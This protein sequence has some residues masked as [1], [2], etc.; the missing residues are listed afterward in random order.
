[1]F[2]TNP[3]SLKKLLDQVDEH[4]IMLPD[5][6]R[7]WVWDD[8][9][10]RGL[11]ASVSLGFP[12]GAIMTL[13]AGGDIR[14]KSRPVE[15]VNDAGAK[16][17]PDSFLL[18]GQQRVTSLYQALRREGPVDTHKH[19]H[20]DARIKRWYYIDMRKAL[21]P[22]IDRED[23]IVSVDAHKKVTRDFG[24]EI[25]VDLSSAKMEYKHHMI[26]TGKVLDPMDWLFG[27]CDHWQK[28]ADERHPDGEVSDFRKAFTNQVL[29]NFTEY[30]LPIIS[31]DKETPKEAVCLV[32]EKVNTGGVTLTT[33]ELVTAVF[34]AEDFQLRDDWEKRK[35]RLS[36]CGVL[37]A[38][39]GEQFLQAVTLLASQSRRRRG[40][41]DGKHPEQSPISCKKRDVLDLSLC[42][43]KEW[44]DQVESGFKKAAKF[45]EEQCIFAEWDVPYNT[46][47]VPLA[48]LYVE[49][50]DA[51]ESADAKE[52]LERWY[53]SGIFSEAYGST[54]ETRFARDLE[55]VAAYIRGAAKPQFMAEASFVPERLISLR[56]RNSAA[57]KGLY[58]LQMKSGAADWRTGRLLSL[59]VWNDEHVD[60]HHIFSKKWCG[61]NCIPKQLCD[62]VINKT[63]IDAKT[64]RIIGGRS[65]SRYLSALD[66]ENKNL[67]RVLRSHW[68]D[69]NS[70]RNDRFAETFIERGQ[71]MFRLINEAM[72]K[73]EAD[74]R[75]AFRNALTQNGLGLPDGNG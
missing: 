51:L 2:K 5:F 72:G 6:Q 38:I 1:M 47:L 15:G 22:N 18:D 60:I 29:N 11:L 20:R 7:G 27:Y 25:V 53:W 56:T 12:I 57:Y 43:Y 68:L 42:D 23:A 48:A 54:V 58:A 17:E 45:L 66:E 3:I 69:P 62:S 41:L 35:Q 73:P 74:G 65:P 28:S 37:K 26:P 32:F 67:D 14:F 31:L 64:N 39:E 50:G 44:A 21:E 70:L 61:E 75:E 46:Q 8:D 24:R 16:A 52:K 13:Q 19:R 10:I 63:P 59:A 71:D 40:S 4:C 34:A 55:Q 33:F 30:Q 36:G 9:H 49:L